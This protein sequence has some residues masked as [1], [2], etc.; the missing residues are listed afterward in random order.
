VDRQNF[1]PGAA[2]TGGAAA[3]GA[4]QNIFAVDGRTVA[5]AWQTQLLTDHE[6]TDD[7]GGARTGQLAWTFWGAPGPGE[8][9]N[10]TTA[11]EY[12]FNDPNFPQNTGKVVVR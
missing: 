2:I 11:G 7:N 1:L 10:D 12:F 3:V 9:G 5:V 6:G 8:Y 4:Q